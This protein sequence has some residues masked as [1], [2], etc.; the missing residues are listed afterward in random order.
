MRRLAAQELANKISI[1]ARIT[2]KLLL[3]PLTE[4]RDELS[5]MS[6]VVSQIQQAASRN[7]A[8]AQRL[9]QGET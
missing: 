2:E 6:L 3:N 8:N 7:P 9:R 5:P 1:V 4:L